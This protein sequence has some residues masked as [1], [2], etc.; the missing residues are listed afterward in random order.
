MTTVVLVVGQFNDCEVYLE[1]VSLGPCWITKVFIGDIDGGDD[2][3][4]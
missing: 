4:G 3:R 2:I 1:G